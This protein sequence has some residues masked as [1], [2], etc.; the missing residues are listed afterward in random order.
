ME[1]ASPL[2]PPSGSKWAEG[3]GSPITVAPSTKGQLTRKKDWKKQP[4]R[5]RP[6]T[7]YY[8]PRG[9]NAS[10]CI[11]CGISSHSATDCPN[12]LCFKCG[13]AKHGPERN[14][15]Y[16][17]CVLCADIGHSTWRCPWRR[18][19]SKNDLKD[20]VCAVCGGKGH[21]TCGDNSQDKTKAQCSNCGSTDHRFDKCP[22]PTFQQIAA[23]DRRQRAAVQ[24]RDR[25]KESMEEQANDMF[26]SLEQQQ[27]EHP[28]N[29]GG[30]K[31]RKKQKKGKNKSADAD[32]SMDAK[33][34][35]DP[36]V[37]KSKKKKESQKTRKKDN[38][39]KKAKKK[40]VAEDRGFAT[41]KGFFRQFAATSI[42]I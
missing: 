4:P 40:A 37:Q 11:F 28:A 9:E 30:G 38:A 22:R 13:D 7:R 18:N 25:E 36:D 34:E 16:Q 21:M 31:K 42:P 24:R 33:S 27:A 41:K 20:C 35:A 6:V 15:N 8:L 17:K 1:I 14:C 12:K 3:M 10:L 26:L 23:S 32:M 2:S 29:V 5:N 19:F 39:K